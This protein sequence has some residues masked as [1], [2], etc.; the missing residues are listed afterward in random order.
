MFGPDRPPCPSELN[1]FWKLVTNNDGHRLAHKLIH[2]MTDRLQ[3]RDRWVNA[4]QNARCALAVIDGAADPVSGA[5]M[6][7][8][9]RELIGKGYV[10]ELAGVGHYPHVETPDLVLEHHAIFLAKAALATCDERSVTGD[11]RKLLRRGL[12]GSMSQVGGV[13]R[14][15]QGL[16]TQRFGV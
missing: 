6:V 12:G 13:R 4:L 16:T 7:A 2:Y 11:K 15:L 8:R 10:V 1:T 3:H 5:H 9:Y 14:L